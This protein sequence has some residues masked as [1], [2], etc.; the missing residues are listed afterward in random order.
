[1]VRELKNISQNDF[2]KLQNDTQIHEKIVLR[3]TADWCAPCK[4]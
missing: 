3:F 4:N 2:I 1:M